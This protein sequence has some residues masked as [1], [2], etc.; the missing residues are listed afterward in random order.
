M[1]HLQRIAKFQSVLEEMR[2]Q[3]L[4]HTF[5]W[6]V[7]GSW[8]LTL[9]RKGVV[10]QIDW[11]GKEQCLIFHQSKARKHPHQWVQVK[12]IQDPSAGDDFEEHIIEFL[13][14]R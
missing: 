5:H 2:T 1:G 8:R 14:Q 11:D 9:R 4:E 10:Y 12:L 13:E 3:I 6:E 7:F